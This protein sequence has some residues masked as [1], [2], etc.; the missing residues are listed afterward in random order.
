MQRKAI[1]DDCKLKHLSSV[2][3]EKYFS[4]LRVKPS[5]TYPTEHYSEKMF[6]VES[7]GHMYRL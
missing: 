1:S 2:V 4:T 6:L 5:I 3:Y 7:N